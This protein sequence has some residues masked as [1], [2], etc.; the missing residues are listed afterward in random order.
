MQ[1][2]F[3]DAWDEIDAAPTHC[4]VVGQ[5]SER[6]ERLMS[7]KIFTAVAV[8]ALTAGPAMARPAAGPIHPGKS[9]YCA[10]IQPGNP[11]SPVYDY[12]AWS[13]WRQRGAWDS[14]GDDRCFQNPH[15]TPYGPYAPPV[16]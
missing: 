2:Q 14:S 11:F 7:L 3:R 16:Y 13:K 6:K 8:L 12:Q 15:Y 10:T 1:P 9:L 5:K 4:Y